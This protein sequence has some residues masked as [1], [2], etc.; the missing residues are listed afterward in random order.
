MNVVISTPDVILFDPPSAKCHVFVKTS[1]Q[2]CPKLEEIGGLTSWGRVE[3]EELDMMQ[4]E[5]GGR[6]QLEPGTP[7]P[8]DETTHLK[9]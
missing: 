1:T 8:P 7:Q 4:Q 3:V 2:A 9:L 6:V 5:V